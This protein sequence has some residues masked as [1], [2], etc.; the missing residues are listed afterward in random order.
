MMIV[1]G[2]LRFL[3]TSHLRRLFGSFDS[4][5][6]PA[7]SAITPEIVPEEL[8]PADERGCAPL[9]NNLMGSMVG[10]AVGGILAAFSNELGNWRGLRNLRRQRHAPVC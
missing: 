7:I 5:F 8:L 9:A 3:G 2:E 1:A 10:P 4:V 6:Y